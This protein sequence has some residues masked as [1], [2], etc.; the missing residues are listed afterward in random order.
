MR[1]C[2]FATPDLLRRTR[3]PLATWSERELQRPPAPVLSERHQP[4]STLSRTR[5]PRRQRDQH[6]TAKGTQ[7]RHPQPT[8]P[9]RISHPNR[10]PE[11]A[12]KHL[13]CCVD[14]QNPPGHH[15]AFNRAGYTCITIPASARPPFRVVGCALTDRLAGNVTGTAYALSGRSHSRAIRASSAVIA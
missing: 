11:I 14:H 12:C 8:P 2:F 3:Q 15:R 1:T 9:S 6:P 10:S 5:R 4:R 7:I 13:M